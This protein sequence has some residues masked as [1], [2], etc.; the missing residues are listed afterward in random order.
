MTTTDRVFV[1]SEKFRKLP[2]ITQALRIGIREDAV[3]RKICT[4]GMDIGDYLEQHKDELETSLLKTAIEAMSQH[5]ETSR[6]I[7]LRN[8]INKILNSRNEIK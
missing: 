2:V 7:T 8:D 5:R 3:A 4:L 1:P 6:V